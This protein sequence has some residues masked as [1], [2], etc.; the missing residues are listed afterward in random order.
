M[1][2]VEGKEFDKYYKAYDYA[3][4]LYNIE[5]RQIEIEKDGKKILVGDVIPANVG[6]YNAT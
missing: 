2:T 1:Y 3:M 4:G 5:Q 6:S